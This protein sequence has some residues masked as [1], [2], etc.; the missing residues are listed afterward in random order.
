MTLA[1]IR[2]PILATGVLAIAVAM[3]CGP[4]PI[5]PTPPTP[6][7]ASVAASRLEGAAHGDGRL[8]DP[9][10][11]WA[12]AQAD[13][14]VRIPILAYLDRHPTPRFIGAIGVIARSGSLTERKLA[15][16]ALVA[17]DRPAARAALA[18]LPLDESAE[19]RRAVCRHLTDRVAGA[20]PVQLDALFAYLG[21]ENPEIRQMAATGLRRRKEDGAVES[22]ARQIATG[23]DLPVRLAALSVL[24][25]FDRT[26]VGGDF[27]KALAE[28]PAAASEIAA[29][30]LVAM[31]SRD[32]LPAVMAGGSAGRPWAAQ[33]LARMGAG[34]E[35]RAYR[36]DPD[37]AV[38]L[39]ASYGR[40][41]GPRPGRL[42]LLIVIDTLRADRL[43][44]YG[45]SDGTSRHLDRLARRGVIYP[46]A[47]SHAPWTLAS[48]VSLFTS[49]YASSLGVRDI[50][51]GLP[52]SAPTIA[53]AMKGQGYVTAAITSVPYLSAA[54]G[55]ERGFD[56]I[57]SQVNQRAER[58][59]DKAI[60]L[61]QSFRHLGAGARRPAGLFLFLHYFDPHEH[62]DPPA[63]WLAA[64]DAGFAGPY[65]PQ[66]R[67][68][69]TAAQLRHL[70]AA[71]AGELAHA[72]E[73]IGRLFAWL[74][75][76]GY[77]RR[78]VYVTSDHGEELG[79]HAHFGH[80]WTLYEE[81]Q[82]VPLVVALAGLPAAIGD[83]PAEL[84]D[85]APTLAARAGAP[86]VAGPGATSLTSSER[87]RVAY[88]ESF[89]K[90]VRLGSLVDDEEKVIET[91]AAAALFDLARDPGE[92][93]DLGFERPEA[94]ARAR[95][96]LAAVRPES[97]RSAD[98]PAGL[99]PDDVE[100]L[101]ALGYLE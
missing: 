81:Q 97:T 38:R 27:V 45:E 53:E 80:G 42:V 83:R 52:A 33:A 36:D 15:I 88:A 22:R 61:L 10:I 98:A 101:K 20:G 41:D 66:A 87:H 48:H 21:D 67:G 91:G 84:R 47:R 44:A 73:E 60:P 13:V 18:R 37:P 57:E 77:D 9:E 89:F 46:V 74:E 17:I 70:Q 14:A 82:R 71:Y 92:V 78:D 93:R 24:A 65:D 1:T 75:R 55:M 34:D 25:G 64:L 26:R 2:Q 31:G 49:R 62:Y 86:W 30:T 12:L 50:Q 11:A 51:D 6:P 58:V 94:M 39:A 43:S 72:D 3:A 23:G 29:D 7:A 85:L 32:G 35:L 56:W 90:G 54:Y 95:A 68:D 63:R 99:A 16:A 69:L 8:T 40:D 4:A 100:A 28:G 19:V 96:A 59:T 5:P 76:L 79:D